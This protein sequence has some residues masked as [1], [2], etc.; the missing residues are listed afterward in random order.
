MFIRNGHV[1]GS[2]LHRGVPSAGAQASEP[3]PV[4]KAAAKKAAAKAAE[5]ETKTP[6][7]KSED[8][9]S[10]AKSEAKPEPVK[11]PAAP[12]LKSALDV[13]KG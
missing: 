12:V 3:E 9:G 7:V 6:P 1:L 5:P 10:E 11:A 8:V 4:K 13:P 2:V